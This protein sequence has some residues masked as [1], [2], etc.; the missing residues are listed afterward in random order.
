MGVGLVLVI[1]AVLLANEAK[2]LLIGEGARPS[3][4]KTIR[5]MVEADPAVEAAGR[6]LTMYL[7][8]ETVLLA[9][10]ILFRR[11]LSANDV[12]Q[13]VDRIEKAVRTKF[14]KIRHISGCANRS[15][16][17]R[18]GLRK[19]ANG[20]W[21]SE[22]KSFVITEVATQKTSKGG[23]SKWLFSVPDDEIYGDTSIPDSARKE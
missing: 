15:R 18:Y 12:T 22:L 16:S 23:I 8:P 19:N 14:P 20:I 5:Q 7:G 13:A 9:L 17:R 3:T 1:S 21:R 2:G 6:P 4:L 10:D 11:S